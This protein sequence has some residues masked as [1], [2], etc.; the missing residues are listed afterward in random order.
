MSGHAERPSGPTIEGS[1]DEGFGA[2]ADA[3]AEGFRSGRELGAAVAVVR[4]GRLVVDL[5]AGTADRLTGRP[6]TGD[7]PAIVYSCT[8]G[9]TTIA[10]YRL[11]E[12]GRLDLDAP[13]AR[14]WP[15]FAANG[16]AKITV[17]HVLSHRAGLPALDRTL[18]REELLAWDPVIEAI[19][20]QR[21]LW[22]PGT[23]YTYHAKT[24][25]W[26]A[27]E[28]IRRVTGMS[29]GTWFR[30]SVA[31]AA[32]AG[33][34]IGVPVEEQAIVART[35]APWPA[36][37]GVPPPPPMT[38]TQVRAV[39]MNGVIPFPDVDGEVSYNAPDIRAAELPGGNGIAS[40]RD[41][42]VIYGAC[43]SD[44][45][46]GGDRAPGGRL[47]SRASIDDALVLRSSGPELLGPHDGSGRWGTGFMLDSPPFRPML[48]PRSFGHDGAG[49]L[50]GFGDDEHAVGF[51]YVTN[52]M[53]GPGD[54]RVQRLVA[55]L[56]SS[57][58]V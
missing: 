35:E 39:T 10:M 45:A 50:L 30:R 41:L 24:F 17:R 48:G 16:K 2:V 5:W 31:E 38:E 19:E 6:W 23:A 20:A 51:G 46:R 37:D 54:D 18:S 44:R 58:G 52:Q 22:E 11:V 28:V 13:V 9:L 57:L 43:V 8:K 7:T 53:G 27:G 15:G 34:R 1:V 25:G 14:Y 26:L 36:P 55:A 40:A 49:G 47:L 56:R 12:E 3:F 21:P 42:A 33:A 29:P 32:G 4:D